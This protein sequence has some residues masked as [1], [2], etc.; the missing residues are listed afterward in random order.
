[1]G[2]RTALLPPPQPRPPSGSLLAPPAGVDHGFLALWGCS[3]P[4]APHLACGQT[5][6]RGPSTPKG[7]GPSCFS[8]HS[9]QFV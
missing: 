2:M 8:L 5:G 9:E 1:M 7:L 4:C 3:S 6:I